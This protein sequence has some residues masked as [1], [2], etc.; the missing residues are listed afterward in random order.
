MNLGAGICCIQVS[1][2]A[3]QPLHVMLKKIE[4]IHQKDDEHTLTIVGTKSAIA[5]RIFP[6]IR[7]KFVHQ[8][9]Y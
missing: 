2:S 5:E 4:I 6:S 9:R 1:S 3:E 7:K 8:H